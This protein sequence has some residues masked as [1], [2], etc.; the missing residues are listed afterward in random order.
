MACCIQVANPRKKTNVMPELPDVELFKKQADKALD[1]TIEDIEVTDSKFIGVAKSTLDKYVK[2]K[3]PQESS[4][5][6][7]Y[8][9]LLMSSSNALIMHFGMTGLL[10]YSKQ[11]S[12]LPE[13]TKC[14][15]LLDNGHQLM[16]ISKRKLGKVE[17]TK[18]LDAWI[19]KTGLGPDALEIS[20]A[21][22]LS[23]FKESRSAIKSFL[24]NQSL[25]AGIGNIYADEILF[26][27]G[28]HPKQKTNSFDPD[29]G[30]KLYGH[31]Q[32][33]LKKAIEKE[34][35]PAKLPDSYLIPK[36]K[37]GAKCPGCGGKVNSYTLSGRRGY[38]CPKC[39]KK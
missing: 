31:M 5:R 27:A 33:V 39:Q 12:D 3:K 32:E 19:D 15:F 14:L 21:D 11:T 23:V 1:T 7:K 28:M 9:F 38:F 34:A 24:T 18:N 29:D 22:F 37:Q 25:M 2:G 36:R 30:K 8:L 26:Q 4:R 20:E 16:Y 10:K 13:Y 35:D 17:F 6:G